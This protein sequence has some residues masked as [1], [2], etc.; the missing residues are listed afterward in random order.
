VWFISPSEMSDLYAFCRWS[1]A[2]GWALGRDSERR[3]S[4]A[5]ILATSCHLFR[6]VLNA[7]LTPAFR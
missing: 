2:H 7:F 1:I 4:R 5:I 3:D 6:R